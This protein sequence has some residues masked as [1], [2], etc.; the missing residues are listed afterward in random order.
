M[1]T[2]CAGLLLLA[3]AITAQAESFFP[4]TVGT[5]WEYDRTG[6]EPGRVTVRIAELAATDGRDLLKLETLTNG[7]LVKS[8]WLSI[9]EQ[10]VFEQRRRIGEQ[11]PVQFNPP[12]LLLPMPLQVGTTWELD[13]EVEGSEMHQ[14]FEVLAEENVTVPAGKFRAWHYRC[15][16]PWPISISIDRWFV[17]GTGVIKDITATHGPGGRLLARTALVLT[18]FTL[19]PPPPEPPPS[20]AI[21]AASPNPTWAAKISLEVMKE[22]EGEP[23][24]TFQADA[25]NI[26]VRWEGRNLPV[27]SVVRVAWIAEDVGDLAEPNFIVDQSNTEVTS[28]EF[29]A[30]FTLSRP[31]DGWAPGKYRVELYLNDI[32]TQKVDVT[33]KE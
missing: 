10:G 17:T 26:F 6:A 12:R 25:P 18:K 11:D 19:A 3:T 33:I 9:D 15:E 8:D 21:S 13:D 7:N 28:S 24:T 2:C 32:L 27:G 16:Q 29:G 23:T 5:S 22:R 30:R 1:R 20:A 14:R 4:R 31:K